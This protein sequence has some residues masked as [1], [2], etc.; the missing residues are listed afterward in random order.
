VQA[1]AQMFTRIGIETKVEVMPW[2][3]YST[4]TGSNEFSVALNSWGVNTGETSN[5]M[6]A[7]LAT[8]DAKAGMGAS[9]SGR[10]SNPALDAKIKEALRTLDEG[11]R[12][13]LL[14]QA[15]DIAFNDVALLPLHQE[16]LVAAARKGLAYATRADQYTLAMDVKPAT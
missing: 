6:V 10:Y 12:N 4:R 5:P 13:A 3:V 14:A 8:V 7:L 15:S 9:N 16:V 11:Q 1:V 2:S